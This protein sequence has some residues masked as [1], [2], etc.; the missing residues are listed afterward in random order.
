MQ[1]TLRAQEQRKRE[2]VEIVVHRR[3]EAR[4][5]KVVR[6]HVMQKSLQQSHVVEMVLSS[7][8]VEYE[9]AI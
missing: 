9:L 4:H 8:S 6:R 7:R 1:Y 5:Y 2:I 3:P